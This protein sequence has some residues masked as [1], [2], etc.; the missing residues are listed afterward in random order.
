MAK[1]YGKKGTL[2]MTNAAKQGLLII[3]VML[4]SAT[5]GVWFYKYNQ[6]DFETLQ[7][8][9]YKW[10]DLEGNWVIINYFAPW[11]AP[12][13]REM[14]E[15]HHLGDNLPPNTS[16]FAINYDVL[17]KDDLQAMADKFGITLNLIMANEETR[18]PIT[19]P[20]YLP[21]TYIVGPQ[22]QVQAEILGEVT[23]DMLKDKIAEL[24]AQAL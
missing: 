15:L 5:A 13:L 24:Q 17:P 2:K 21:A 23:A 12:C 4:L 14:P 16:L 11:C 1:K 18:L 8:G 7:G 10:R 3:L 22:G 19:K 9:D 6:T 20:P